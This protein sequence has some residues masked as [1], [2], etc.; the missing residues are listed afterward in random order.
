MRMYFGMP[1]LA[2]YF[3][4]QF[5]GQFACTIAILE[6]SRILKVTDVGSFITS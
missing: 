2:Q 5:N 4:L 3:L 1:L 6:W